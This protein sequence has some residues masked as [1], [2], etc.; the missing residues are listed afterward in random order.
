MLF[1]NLMA[2][3]NFDPGK[4][5]AALLFESGNTGVHLV[6]L[7]LDGPDFRLKIIDSGLDVSDVRC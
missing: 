2:L 6:D 7:D 1:S 5:V 3:E 4:C